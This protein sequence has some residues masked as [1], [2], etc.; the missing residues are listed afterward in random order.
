MG[1][2]GHLTG[3]DGSSTLRIN[4]GSGSV[5]IV[6]E[7]RDDIHVR[8]ADVE[9]DVVA[10]VNIWTINKTSGRVT[11]HVPTNTNLLIGTTSGSTKVEGRTGRTV[12]MTASGRVH[13]E[14]AEEVDIRVKSG[15]VRVDQCDGDCCIRCDSGSVKVIN[16]G[17]CDVHAKSGRVSIENADGD[18][19]I[20][21]LSGAVEVG[22]A[23][24]HDADIEAM[25]GR[26]TVTVPDGVHLDVDAETGTG[27]LVN[28]VPD[29]TDASVKVRTSSGRI[30]ISTADDR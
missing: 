5:R 6:A 22:F 26:V 13:V 7:D 20:R 12:V 3:N 21:A 25:S 27:N 15:T 29:G 16:A 8:G 1:T 11:A 23:G 18:T 14:N 28:T 30:K 17:A 19:A 4:S 24:A 10:G 9:H 2:E